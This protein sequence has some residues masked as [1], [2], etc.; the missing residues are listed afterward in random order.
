VPNDQVI[1]KLPHR[2][3]CTGPIV[4]CIQK[5]LETAV[6]SSD[7]V[8][9]R[10]RHQKSWLD[11][12]TFLKKISCANASNFIT[13]AA[14]VTRMSSYVPSRCLAGGVPG[15]HTCLSALAERLKPLAL[16]LTSLLRPARGCLKFCL[17]E[18]AGLR[19]RAALLKA[20][21]L[22]GEAASAQ[23]E[24]CCRN[25]SRVCP[26]SNVEAMKLTK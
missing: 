3:Q 13:A 22:L 24:E 10:P 4:Q 26:R 9:C 7:Q 11:D 17:K 8:P 1:K 12:Q 20:A 23:C 5:I 19:L 25:V 6:F 18:S 2:Y 14:A 16:T 15:S 21:L